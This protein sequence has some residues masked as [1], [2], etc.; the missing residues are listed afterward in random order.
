VVVV[1]GDGDEAACDALST[2]A[3][4]PYSA[5]VAAGGAPSAD[6]VPELVSYQSGN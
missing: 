1:G 5:A 2:P 3:G 6:H 4:I